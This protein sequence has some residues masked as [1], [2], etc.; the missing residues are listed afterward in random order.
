MHTKRD[1]IEFID[2]LAAKARVSKQDMDT[3]YKI[4]NVLI[5]GFESDLKWRIHLNISFYTTFNN[6]TVNLHADVIAG[7]QKKLE[8]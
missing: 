4:T 5:G 8:R 1:K 3:L 2:N 6:T 7:Q